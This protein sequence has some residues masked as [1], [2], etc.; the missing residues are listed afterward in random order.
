[1]PNRDDR[2]EPEDFEA[3][4][5]GD[6][7]SADEQGWE[8]PTRPDRPII[9]RNGASHAGGRQPMDDFERDRSRVERD[10]ARRETD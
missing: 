10:R 2:D 7:G 6:G 3:P 9:R 8:A 1:M 5:V 4:L